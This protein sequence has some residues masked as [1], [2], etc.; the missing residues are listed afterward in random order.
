MPVL[1]VIILWHQHQPFYKDLVTGEYR[2]PWVR[3]HALKDYYGMVKLLDEFP[4]VHQTF[5][6]VPSLITQI[7]DYVAGTAQDPFLRVAAKP[8]TDLTLDERRFALQYLFQANPVNMIARYPR[9]HELW[10]RF[11]S[12]GDSTER[13]EKYFQPQDFTDLQVLS[14]IA[15]FDE[16]FLED[17][18]VVALI[19]KARGYSL[20]DQRFVIARERELVAKVLP[21][22]A[23][24][25]QR[26]AI[27]ISTSPFYHPILPLVCDTNMGAVSTPGLP[28]PQNRFRHPEDAREQLL[29]GLDLHRQVFGIRPQ[30]VWPSEGSVS[31]ETLAIAQNLGAKWM[32]TDEE[33]LG[34]S[35][36]V[37]F[38]RDG[39][40]RLAPDAAEKLYTIHHF[41]NH[42]SEM[43]LIF[44]DHAISDLIGFVYSGMP[45]RDAAKHL[46]HNIKQAA[47][48][49]LSKGRDAVVPIILDGENAWEY[50][51]QSG[52]EFLRRFYDGLQRE[53]D[54]EALTVSE[55]VA[56][57]KNFAKLT[58]LVPGSWIHA[59]FNVW[60]G[61]P[62]DNR[63]WDYLYHARNFY[64]Q[65]A[66]GATEAQRKLAF[67]EILI[68]EG[69]DW[70]WW[71]GPEHHSANDQEFDEL[72]RKHL[73][74]VY[75]ALGA[76]PP[77][78]LAQPIIGGAARP[79]FVPQTAYIHP[80]VTGDMVRYFE[81]M[82]AAVY[83]ADKRAGAMHG[84]TFFMDAVY[85]GIDEANVY[86]RLDFIDRVP[87]MEFE[88]VVNLESWAQEGQRPRR[89][90]RLDVTVEGG[91]IEA[92]KVSTPDEEKP[93]A[94]SAN[95]GT[96]A[97]AVLVRNFEFK[98]PLEW[99][100]ALPVS[101]ST[102]KVATPIVTRL[103][104]RFS[105]WH[106]GLPID[107]LPVEGWME[108]Q[109][110]PEEELI[111]G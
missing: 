106:N 27:E 34:R 45:P 60:I 95:R 9:Y 84:K 51:P 85:A 3:L 10:E 40:G 81:W 18:D 47:Q 100:L 32:A 37:S 5:N 97:A 53:P 6:L 24:A 89:A 93:L 56:R 29:R 66:G 8:A 78:Y 25:A 1:R 101:P 12:T 44:R 86:G 110:V 70:N 16:F 88:L 35:I 54:I 50:Y 43:H 11:R 67:E 108:L 71:Y 26:G 107:A 98:L 49:I 87:E 41:E 77:D 75:Q 63:A 72:Y 38:S 83:T 68:A 92:R 2:L 30:G 14:Q 80:R 74:N 15:W 19:K 13:A 36:G 31:E 33:V 21:A 57:H 94:T 4:N 79:S 64:A 61:A 103:R 73:S 109:L 48:S 7:Q 22:H 23:E 28:L 20:D 55:A 65:A 104:L 52:R 99:L 76:R 42:Q 105:L 62:E 59:N 102:A 17:G 82:G 96:D 39:S 111:L 90:L 58:S 69:S 91:K 46:I